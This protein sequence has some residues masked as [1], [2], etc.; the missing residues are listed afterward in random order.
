MSKVDTVAF[1]PARKG[2]KR[3]PN[4]NFMLVENI[5][6]IRRTID[7]LNASDVF[8][9]IIVSTDAPNEAKE[10]FASYSSVRVIPRNEILSSDD[11]T[12]NQVLLE[13]FERIQRELYICCVYPTNALLRANTIRTSYE[14]FLRDSPTSLMGVS[15]FKFKVDKAM[16]MNDK[17]L[18][19]PFNPSL[20]NRKTQD[21]DDYFISNGTFYWTTRTSLI[22]FK[23]VISNPLKGFLVEDDEVCDLDEPSDLKEFSMKFKFRSKSP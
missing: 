2:S 20:V 9:E 7:T 16:R 4:K 6:L 1:V 13:Y 12:V 10:L 3:L 14:T 8:K 15:K 17:N 21:L 18:L 23:S 19:E 11:S 5:P 22:H